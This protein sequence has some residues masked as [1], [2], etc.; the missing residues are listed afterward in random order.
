MIQ[1]E[2]IFKVLEDTKC[3]TN[4]TIFKAVRFLLNIGIGFNYFL[5]QWQRIY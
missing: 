4:L 3:M 1:S 2:F 5:F